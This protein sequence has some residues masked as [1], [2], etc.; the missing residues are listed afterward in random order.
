M[1]S[2]GKKDG[3]KE[4]CGVVLWLVRSIG[5]WKEN[6][7]PTQHTAVRTW[8]PWGD[9]SYLISLGATEGPTF[10]AEVSQLRLMLVNS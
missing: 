1:N 4:A 5:N 7:L 3:R 6:T 8:S 2:V 9:D 10:G